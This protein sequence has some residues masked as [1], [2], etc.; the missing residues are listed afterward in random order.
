MMIIRVIILIWSIL[1]IGQ[2]N[3][4]ELQFAIADDAVFCNKHM[5]LH[6]Q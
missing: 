3:G 4:R 2:K 5:W 1:I 6:A